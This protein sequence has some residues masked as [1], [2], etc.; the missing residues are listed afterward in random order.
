MTSLSFWAQALDNVSDDH[1]QTNGQIVDE[2]NRL[3]RRQLA[4]NI[5]RLTRGYV[6][7]EDR[8]VTLTHDKFD[9]IIRVSCIQKDAGGRTSTVVCFGRAPIN[10]NDAWIES[11]ID[12][13]KHFADSIGRS[14]ESD[15]LSNISHSFWRFKKKVLTFFILAVGVVLVGVAA[16][17]MAFGFPFRMYFAKPY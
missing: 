5:S 16:V 14:L 2:S 13:L 8:N 17:A 15:A 6:L 11:V 3:L 9:F 4:A 1:F 12:E 10:I 7:F